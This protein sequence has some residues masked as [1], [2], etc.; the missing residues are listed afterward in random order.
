MITSLPDR[1]PLCAAALACCLLAG[2]PAVM[3]FGP[4][5]SSLPRI[6]D[7][8]L[9]SALARTAR[10]LIRKNIDPYPDGLVHR[11]NSEQ[12]GDAVSEAQA[13][14]MI[15]ALYSGDQA[16]F[17][18]VWDAAEN[19]M[20]NGGTHLYDWR[21]GA[22]GGPIEKG[23][24]TDADQDIALMLLF[25][26]SLARKG[27][28]KPHTGPKGANYLN[29][30]KE[31]I[32]NIWGSAVVEGR[33]LAPGSGWGGKEF[34]NP[35]Y[36]SPAN[37][38]IFAKVD[39]GHNWN[40][41]IDQCYQTLSANP[42][43]DKG[44]LPDW[45]TPGGGFFEGTLGYN[46]FRS[47]KSHYKDAIRVHWRMA[48][49]WLWFAEPRAKRWLDAASAFIRT[50]DRANFYTL[51]GNP[52]PASETFTLGDGQSRS[53]REYSELT[54]GM[55]ACAAFVAQG[56]TAAKP[57]ADSLL[58][59]LPAGSDTWGRPSDLSI[60]DRSGSLP[61]EQYFEQY[62]AWFGAAVLAGRFSNVWE[63]LRNPR[64]GI[65]GRP[66]SRER[67][68][69]RASPVLVFRHGMPQVLWTAHGK[70]GWLALD[71][72]KR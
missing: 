9:D 13:Y 53:R 71:G 16:T 61:N 3:A 49:D 7:D 45:M 36:F 17:N 1:S 5:A 35:G 19:K 52:L 70:T 51:D 68:G 44:L 47:G 20:W 60:P 46:A 65:A 33:Y 38:R 34:V 22:N 55:W 62:L 63:D 43:A 48:M 41:V 32:G 58:A 12:P 69:E 54:V 56:P 24:A 39:P 4:T 72:G 14:G 30:A 42:G 31:I 66:D 26:D 29:R 2:A 67:L 57:W 10:G 23:M 15:V 50:P 25:A 37:Y 11:P 6:A 28:W 40:A 27:I 21:L 64:V 18:R 8:R 59:F